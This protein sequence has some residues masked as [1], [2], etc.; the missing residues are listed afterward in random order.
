[1]NCGHSLVWFRTSA[2]HYRKSIDFEAFA[3]WLKETHCKK[4]VHYQTVY[5]KDYFDVLFHPN[6]ASV[7]LSLSKAKRRLVMA[8]L[9][10]LAKFLGKYQQWKNTIKEY[11]LKWEQRNNLE[12]FLSL[13]NTNINEVKEWLFNIL[14]KLP[15]KYKTALVYQTL[16]GLRP[17]EACM[18]LK[19]LGVLK[20]QNKLSDYY[21]RDLKMLQ[22]FR[23]KQFLRKSKNAY[24]SF[25]SDSLLENALKVKYNQDYYA[26][27]SYIKK[28]KF[29]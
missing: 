4:V 6:K 23:Y 18:S 29:P 5:A 24:I 3:N 13:L 10:N 21:D 9:S 20:E 17:N 1:V 28:K 27:Q 11:G 14:S 8:S 7:L 15:L 12:T 16:T 19:L 2:C 26:I 22:H 25:I